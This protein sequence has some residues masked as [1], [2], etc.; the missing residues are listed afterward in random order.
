MKEIP[1]LVL[2]TDPVLLAEKLMHHFGRKVF[3]KHW[4]PCTI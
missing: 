1:G 3:I 2:I 4:K